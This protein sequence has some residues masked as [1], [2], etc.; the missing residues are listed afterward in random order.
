MPKCIMEIFSRRLSVTKCDSMSVFF[1]RH[2]DDDGDG[3]GDEST[4]S[5]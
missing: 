2:D 5:I 1:T 4:R 3:D